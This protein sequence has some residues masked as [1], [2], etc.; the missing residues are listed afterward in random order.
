MLRV[1]V[2]FIALS[3]F[4]LQLTAAEQTLHLVSP[5]KS[6]LSEPV[7][8]QIA[9]ENSI[10]HARFEVK[11]SEINGKEHLGKDEYP[12]QF[13][14]VELFVSV[15]GLEGGR[16]PYYEFEVSPYN[17]D[18]QVR[19]IDLK[20]TFQEGLQLGL[21]HYVERTKDG[22]IADLWIPLENLNW[23]YDPSKIVGNAYA[24]LGKKPNRSFWSLSLPPMNKPNFHQPQYFQKLLGQPNQYGELIP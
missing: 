2:A 14:V 17:E 19:I 13:D 6:E 7:K 22:W 16:V 24:I 3:F 23:N 15:V 4:S 12:Y 10:L 11:T 20:K 1:S 21:Q 5:Q 18:F 8:I 9:L